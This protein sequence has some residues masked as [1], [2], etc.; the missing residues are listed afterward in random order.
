MGMVLK[1]NQKISLDF[2][3]YSIRLLSNRPQ[4]MAQRLNLGKDKYIEYYHSPGSLPGVIF[5]P[6][7]MSNMNGTKAL[8]LE[9]FC[10]ATGRAYTRFDHRGMGLSSGKPEECTIG[11]RKE[12]VLSLLHVVK[13]P[14]ILVG[15]SLGGWIMF[16]VAMKI[17]HRIQGLVGIATAVD[18]LSRR[19]DSLP[20]ETKEEIKTT[21]EWLLPTPYSENPY[22]LTWDMIQDARRH[23]LGDSTP[24]HCPI[25]LIHGMKDEEVPYKVS[26][27]VAKG[28]QSKDVNVILVKDGYH[29]LSEPK[30][31][32][33]IT[34]TIQ[35]LVQELSLPT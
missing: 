14:Q 25:R 1:K 24:V 5:L 18:F 22:I 9:K 12:D 33:L 32:L 30:N 19:F 7:L 28:V 15:S 23:V 17:P 34:R 35:E 11:S 16:L 4:I 26:L 8:A 3:N 27:D 10:Q 6:G 29:R 21:G 2:F 31:I 20:E 13:G